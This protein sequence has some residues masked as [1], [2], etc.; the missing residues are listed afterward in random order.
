M[1]DNETPL[2]QT[3]EVIP[4][5]PW[6]EVTRLKVYTS[7][8]RRLSWLQVWQ[9]FQG[10]YP[11]RW[12]LELYPPAEDLVD[13]AHIYHLWLLPEGWLPP[14]GMNLAARIQA[15]GRQMPEIS[16]DDSLEA[17]RQSLRELVETGKLLQHVAVFPERFEYSDYRA[18]WDLQRP[19]IPVTEALYQELLLRLKAKQYD[20]FLW[21][22]RLFTIGNADGGY[23]LMPLLAEREAYYLNHRHGMS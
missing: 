4:L 1:M 21:A 14:E 9:A 3:L 16:E 11:G 7:D 22:G 13:D 10:A 2:V 20:F 18:I 12:A 19:Y 8:Y 6:G 23:A 5:P 17:W 15:A